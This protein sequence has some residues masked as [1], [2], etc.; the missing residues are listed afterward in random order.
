MAAPPANPAAPAGPPDTVDDIVH[1]IRIVLESNASTDE[2]KRLINELR[3]ARPALQDRWLYRWVV[4]F[5][6]AAAVGAII[7]ISWLVTE[8]SDAPD[9]LIALGS[10]AVGALAGLLAPGSQSGE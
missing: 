7:A 2:K 4:W 1:L 6:G 8:G 9:G 10:A 5:L 3:K